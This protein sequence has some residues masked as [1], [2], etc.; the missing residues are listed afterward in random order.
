M[1]VS[2][3]GG[4]RREL[5]RLS[6]DALGGTHQRRQRKTALVVTEVVNLG[7]NSEVTGKVVKKVRRVNIGVQLL[8]VKRQLFGLK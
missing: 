3:A 8:C 2:Q 6:A 4:H 1:K 7:L 5:P